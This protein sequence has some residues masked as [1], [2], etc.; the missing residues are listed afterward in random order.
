MAD[1]TTGNDAPLDEDAFAEAF[2]AKSARF[3]DHIPSMAPGDSDVIDD[4]GESG[5][6]TV[7]LLEKG[8]AALG[9]TRDNEVLEA[10]IVDV[11]ENFGEMHFTEDLE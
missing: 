1:D 7:T 4:D 8:V 5:Q 6:L 3:T 11:P 2:G 10:E 9:L